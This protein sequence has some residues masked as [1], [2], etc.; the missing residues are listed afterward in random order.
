MYQKLGVPAPAFGACCLPVVVGNVV[1]MNVGG[2]GCCL[3][4]FNT[5]D[6]AVLW[7]NYDEPSSTS[8]PVLMAGPAQP[9]KLPDVVFMTTLRLLAVNPLDGSLSWEF[10]LVF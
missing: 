1:L 7:K 9:G 5:A 8:S 6:G 3:V 10:P 4:G 2:K